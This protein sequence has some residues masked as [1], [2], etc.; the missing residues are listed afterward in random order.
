MCLLL[1]IVLK[2]FHVSKYLYYDMNLET[3]STNELGCENTILC[4][5]FENIS[6]F[7]PVLLFFFGLWL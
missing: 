6:L 2:I 3:H 1:Y 5:S 4:S 7:F